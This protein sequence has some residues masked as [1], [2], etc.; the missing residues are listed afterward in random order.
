MPFEVQYDDNGVACWPALGVNYTNKTQF[1]FR[2]NKGIYDKEELFRYRLITTPL[3]FL[4]NLTYP[5][6]LLKH[7]MKPVT[8][9]QRMLIYEREPSKDSEDNRINY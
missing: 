6:V 4:W 2:I 1:L 7:I 5:R 3:K 9:N 8:V